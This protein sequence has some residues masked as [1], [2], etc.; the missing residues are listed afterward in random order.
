MLVYE[1]HEDQWWRAEST[2]TSKRG[3]IP[4]NY[5]EVGQKQPVGGEWDRVGDVAGLWLCPPYASHPRH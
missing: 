5:V 4:V 3:T 2:T 1:K